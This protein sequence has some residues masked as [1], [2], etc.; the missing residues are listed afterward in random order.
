M[1]NVGDKYIQ[2]LVGKPKWMGPFRRPRYRWEDNIRMDLGEIGW[3][4]MGLISM[5]Q[6]RVL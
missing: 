6:N 3:E 1:Y 2:N 5:A 4:G